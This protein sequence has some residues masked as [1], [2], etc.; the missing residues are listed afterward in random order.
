L[1]RRGDKVNAPTTKIVTPATMSKMLNGS[2]NRLAR[3]GKRD[4]GM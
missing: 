3:R 1:K 4:S 2:S